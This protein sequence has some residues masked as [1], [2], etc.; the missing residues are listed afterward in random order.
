[1]EDKTHCTHH[2][3]QPAEYVCPA[4]KYLPLCKSC[5]QSHAKDTGH[6]PDN[7][8]EVGRALL[9]QRI[10]E[11]GEKPIKVMKKFV[12]E[13]AETL[14]QG[15]ERFRPECAL[16]ELRQLEAEGMYVELYL[17][18]KSL[19]D[20]VT[21]KELSE[22]VLKTLDA[23]HAELDK[24]RDKVIAQAKSVDPKSAGVYVFRGELST[25]EEQV[26]SALKT[27]NVPKLKELYVYPKCQIGNKVAQEL[28]PMIQSGELTAVCIEGANI[29]NADAAEL[30][31]AAFHNKA[32][33]TF[34]MWS[35]R[36]SYNGVMELAKAARDCR[37]LTTFYLSGE[38]ISDLEAEAVANAV[39][40]CPLS[41]FGI[42]GIG[43]TDT[44]AATVSE[45]ISGC[46]RTM[47]VIY[48]GGSS[49]LAAGA[50]KVV[51]AVRSCP[52]ISAVYFDGG[53]L[54]GE[55]L[56]YVLEAVAGISSIRSVNLRISNIS[57]ANMDS[58]LTTLQH[59]RVGS[60]LKLRFE[61][62]DRAQSVCEKCADEWKGRFEE[63]R[64]VKR[65]RDL[66]VEE[67]ILG[68]KR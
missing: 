30:A 12:K 47:S 40:D 65:I 14:V 66:F 59:I 43:I 38:G 49:I 33:S 28:A 23:A 11:A 55:V 31:R 35:R 26:V 54:A 50:K 53:E 61:C 6:S 5:K 9:R 37:L 19:H 18:V 56:G 2:H 10:Q 60:S 16:K 20:G 46:R 27:A 32:L 62:G 15:V 44:G 57:K 22:C 64:L 67:V 36:I 25:T 13:L 51:E 63:F 42:W 4:C 7:C 17:G 58:C 41:V 29:N 21:T 39:R 68:A 3:D 52:R 34:G 48:F 8:R 1:M 45:M 24:L